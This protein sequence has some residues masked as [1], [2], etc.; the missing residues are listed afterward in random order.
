M[1]A[2]CVVTARNLD[3]PSM[4]LYCT[5]VMN[6]LCMGLWELE[7][8]QRD[9]AEGSIS[10]RIHSAHYHLSSPHR[11]CY[12][13]TVLL[14]MF[15]MDSREFFALLADIMLLSLYKLPSSAVTTLLS[16][17]GSPPRP[18][19]FPVRGVW[20]QICIGSAAEQVSPSRIIGFMAEATVVINH[21]KLPD[22]TT[23][24]STTI[25]TVKVILIIMCT[26]LE[27]YR[28]SIFSFFLRLKR[29]R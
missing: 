19:Q 20:L 16:P 18:S 14:M 7:W 4:L 5:L 28:T 24:I 3:S 6:M 15:K 22:C 17:T 8:C 9:H 25:F 29:A 2:C 13:C 11:F 10:S 1:Q 12:S 27:N 21:N 23:W 26:W